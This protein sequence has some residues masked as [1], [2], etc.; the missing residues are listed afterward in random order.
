MGAATDSGYA[1]NAS[2][3][4]EREDKP[5]NALAKSNSGGRT[6]RSSKENGKP[7]NGRSRVSSRRTA[8]HRASLLGQTHTANHAP[9][10]EDMIS[11]EPF[12]DDEAAPSDAPGTTLESSGWKSPFSSRGSPG[13]ACRNSAGERSVFSRPAYPLRDVRSAPWSFAP[14]RGRSRGLAKVA[15]STTPVRPDDLPPIRPFVSK[16]EPLPPL[17]VTAKAVG[18]ARGSNF[19]SSRGMSSRLGTSRFVSLRPSSF[20]RSS[21]L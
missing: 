13:V 2:G 10:D 7:S 15:A 3:E 8:R 20:S 4:K 11:L 16:G 19:L 12:Q 17:P 9:N 5:E 14:N 1:L 18:A 21:A 6:R